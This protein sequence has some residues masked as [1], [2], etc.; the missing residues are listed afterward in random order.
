M[1]SWRILL[2]V[3]L[4]LAAWLAWADPVAAMASAVVQND[5]M[6]IDSI[7]ALH[8]FGEVK[9][10]G[11]VWLRFVKVTGTLRDST[12]A[13]V[14]VVFTYTLLTFVPPDAVAPFNM[15]EIDTTKS[16]RTESY[17]LLLEFQEATALSQQLA[18]L[19]LADS[20]NSLGW[21]EVVGEV[22]N[23]GTAPSTY[24]QVAGT[25]YDADGKVIYVHFT[26]TDPS[27]IPPGAKH[28]F[29]ITVGSDE[30]TSKIAR[31]IV[32]AESENSGYTSVPEFAWAPLITA[33]AL[34]LTVVSIKR[35]KP[36]QLAM[37]WS[38]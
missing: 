3:L 26:Y 4:P 13:I 21:L 8:I 27:E 19:N 11:D 22:E 33:A 32:M 7:G 9:N 35:K 12:G 25:F 37:F 28:P 29:K 31:Y 20:K 34:T 1:K 24:T 16:A 2:L 23:R 38:P 36:K 30:R 14:D 6:W 5:S 18:V 17:S 15:I 10:T